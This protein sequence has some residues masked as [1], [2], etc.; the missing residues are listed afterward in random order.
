VHLAE[1]DVTRQAVQQTEIH[2]IVQNME[3]YEQEFSVQ[4]STGDLDLPT[5]KTLLKLY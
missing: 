5:I 3:N 2:V 1:G 4:E